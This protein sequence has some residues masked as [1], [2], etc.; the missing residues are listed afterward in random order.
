[1]L[2]RS[3]RPS[4]LPLQPCRLSPSSRPRHA[5]Q[6]SHRS[7]QTGTKSG[8]P[9][10]PRRARSSDSR[11]TCSGTPFPPRIRGRSSIGRSR[12]CSRIWPGRSLRR[13]GGRGQAGVRPPGL[14]TSRPGSSVRSGSGTAVVAPSWAP[15]GTDAPPGGSSSSITCARFAAGGEATFENIELRCRAHNAYEA[16]LYYGPSRPIGGEGVVREAPVRYWPRGAPNLPR[17]ELSHRR[18]SAE[19]ASVSSS[20]RWADLEAFELP[21]KRCSR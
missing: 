11:K 7:R 3:H 2:K 15:P 5:D 17:N 6:P 10:A 20:W 18:S 16:E 14:A 21:S 12:R 9:P 4:L 13:R 1:M 8:S 19:T